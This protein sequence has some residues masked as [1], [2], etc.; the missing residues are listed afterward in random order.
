MNKKII[1]IGAGGHGKVCAEIAGFIGYEEIVFLDDNINRPSG[2]TISGTTA[3]YEKFIGGDFFVAL[4][5]N[6]LRRMFQEKIIGSGGSM[7]KLIHP[8]AIVSKATAIGE[9][10]VVMAGAVI[11]PGAVIGDGAIINTCS[12]VDHDCR[13][14]DFAHIAVGTHLAGLVSVGENT[15]IGAGSTVVNTVLIPRDTTVGAGAAVIKSLPCP[16]T[17]V[18]VP[19]RRIK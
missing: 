5:D 2:F 15:F 7:A 8:R 6:R 16:G 17:Y 12:S 1:I 9:G 13:I 11:N 10:S 14:G 3:D 19:A 18:G 4:G